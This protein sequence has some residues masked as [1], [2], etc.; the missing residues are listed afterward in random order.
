MGSL[1]EA[2]LAKKKQLSGITVRPMVS[3]K[4]IGR[5]NDAKPKITDH[6]SIEDIDGCFSMRKFKEMAE[7][8]LLDDTADITD[9]V[10][11]AHRF[12]D[13]RKPENKKFIWFF[14]ELRDRLKKLPPAKHGELFRKAFRKSGATFELSE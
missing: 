11:K 12:K 6:F 5:V 4:E 3:K 7:R 10:Q 1:Q 13:D 2:L 9:I 14:Y 8:I